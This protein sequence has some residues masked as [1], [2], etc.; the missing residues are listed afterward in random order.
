MDEQMN[1]D[2]QPRGPGE[3]TFWNRTIPCLGVILLVAWPLLSYDVVDAER[4]R[5]K[6][7]SARV[8]WDQ[9]DQEKALEAIDQAVELDPGNVAALVDRARW[10]GELWGY[11]ANPGRDRT[12]V[13]GSKAILGRNDSGLIYIQTSNN[14]EILNAN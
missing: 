14:E 6:H 9:G 5:W 2:R 13:Y 3:G 11:L 8:A 7:A 10:L 1:D 4:G 12:V